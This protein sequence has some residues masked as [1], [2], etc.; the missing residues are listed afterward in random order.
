MKRGQVVMC[1]VL[2][3]LSKCCKASVAAARAVLAIHFEVIEEGQNQLCVQV[4]ECE[5]LR[6]CSE[7]AFRK[8][9]QKSE[10]VPVSGDG[11]E[12]DAPMLLQVIDEEALQER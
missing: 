10:C 4:F 11:P 7:A 6:F 3:K 8:D 1:R 2:E 9:K 5:V 12:A